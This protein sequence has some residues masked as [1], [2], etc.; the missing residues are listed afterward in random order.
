MPLSANIDEPLRELCLTGPLVLKA[1]RS[2]QCPPEDG[3]DPRYG[4]LL[5]NSH[6][7]TVKQGTVRTRSVGDS[8]LPVLLECGFQS[9]VITHSTA[10]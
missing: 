6:G 3:G 10:K 1:G 8:G 4:A 7:R 9:K 5:C 2:A